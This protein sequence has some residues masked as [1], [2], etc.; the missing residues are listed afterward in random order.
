VLLSD[1]ECNEGAVWEAVMFATHHR[2]SSL[3]AIVDLNGQQAL[4]YTNDVLDLTSLTA[5]WREFGWDAREVDGHD[6]AALHRAIAGLSAVPD[7]PHVIVA[8]TIAGKGVS[9]MERRIDWHYLPMTLDQYD[10][11]CRDV[12]GPTP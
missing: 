10:R 9:F 8:R 11:A 7:R 12:E 1:A 3:V 4:G 5:K 6:V 2:L